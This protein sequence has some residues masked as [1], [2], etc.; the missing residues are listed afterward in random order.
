[1]DGTMLQS[2]HTISDANKEIMIALQ[3]KG[4]LVVP[5]SARPLHGMLPI[6]K[7]VINDSMPVVS[8][9]GSYIFQSNEIIR[10]FTIP[11]TDA[12]AIHAGLL[13]DDVTMMY[14]S[15]MDWFA[16][17]ETELVQKEQKITPVKITIEP[18]EKIV[19]AWESKN[20]GPNKILIAGDQD[21]VALVEQNL[22]GI[23]NGKLNIYKSQPRYLEVMNRE[24]SKTK[25][26]GFLMSR[27]GISREEII[28]IGDNYNDKEMIAFAGTG[29]AM[30]NAPD[31]IKKVADYVTDTNNAD[32]VAK[33]LH[34]FFG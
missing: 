5:V 26:V 22:L 4:I 31:D 28:A 13:H 27:Y 18:F 21:I 7:G 16:A 34:H 33:A 20:N 9:N 19:G 15:Q 11:L 2:D 12:I 17:A 32:G 6:L 30:G 25:A 23:Y 3:Q 24:A 14:Y 29:V 1:M 8:L 10:Q